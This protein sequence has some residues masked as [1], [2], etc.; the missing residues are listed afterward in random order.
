MLVIPL[1]T[2]LNLWKPIYALPNLQ[3]FK[4]LVDKRMLIASHALKITP[5]IVESS[6]SK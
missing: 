1:I 2:I 3:I 5:A 4:N 6:L